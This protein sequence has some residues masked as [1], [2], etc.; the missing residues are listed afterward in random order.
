M[1][2][3]TATCQS[4]LQRRARAAV[5]HFWIYLITLP[6]CGGIPASTTL[7][8][9]PAWFP[10]SPVRHPPRSQGVHLCWAAPTSMVWIT[11]RLTTHLEPFGRA[12]RGRRLPHNDRIGTTRR[13]LAWHL[14]VGSYP[15][16]RS[17]VPSRCNW[18]SRL[19]HSPRVRFRSSTYITFELSGY[20]RS[21]GT[22]GRT[23]AI[24]Y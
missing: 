2:G 1:G 13:G 15:P 16:P 8:H 18:R 17:P 6:R 10:H 22:P 23:V 3:K 19:R 9:N 24:P 7:H 21:I 20:I 5:L 4:V 12:G 11:L 14:P